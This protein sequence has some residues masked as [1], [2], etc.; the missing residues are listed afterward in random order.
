MRNSTNIFLINLSVADLL[1]LLICTPTVLVELNTAPETWVL[2]ERMCKF[3]PDTLETWRVFS[4]HRS[5]RIDAIVIRIYSYFYD[6]ILSKL[7]EKPI[8]YQ[9]QETDRFFTSCSECERHYELSY[10]NVN[11]LWCDFF[12][13]SLSLFISQVNWF[14]SSSLPL[15]TPASW[16]YWL[17][18]SSAITLSANR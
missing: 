14:H 6:F 3:C 9:S 13:L 4:L 8:G 18:H 1:V 10:W 15:H 12:C 17:Y 11:A 2:G 7:E 16:Q 5:I